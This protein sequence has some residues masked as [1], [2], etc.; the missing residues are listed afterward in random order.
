MAFA[1]LPEDIVCLSVPDG[2]D[3]RPAIEFL[4]S[5]ADSK[6]KERSAW[7]ISV[8]NACHECRLSSS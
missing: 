2:D 7:A 4:R 6:D 5:W 8:W 1:E 3:L